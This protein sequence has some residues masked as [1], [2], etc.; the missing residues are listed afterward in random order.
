MVREALTKSEQPRLWRQPCNTPA[1]QL[2]PLCCIKCFSSFPLI[3]EVF[4]QCSWMLSWNNTAE[5]RWLASCTVCVGQVRMGNV[6][7]RPCLPRAP[8]KNGAQ[9]DFRYCC[10]R[11][12]VPPTKSESLCTRRVCQTVSVDGW[13]WRWSE[14]HGYHFILKSHEQLLPILYFLFPL[15]YFSAPEHLVGDYLSFFGLP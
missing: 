5:T 14:D 4:A 15:L 6:W 8:V 7:T 1:S 11:C 12:N 9:I 3:T 2:S 13:W 10:V